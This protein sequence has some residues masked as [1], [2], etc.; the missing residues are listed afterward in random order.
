VYIYTSHFGGG[1]PQTKED[2]QHQ[3]EERLKTREKEKKIKSAQR[4]ATPPSVVAKEK[5]KKE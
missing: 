4:K 5:R 1:C 2:E 3:K